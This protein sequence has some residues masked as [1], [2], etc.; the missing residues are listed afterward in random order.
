MMLMV[1]HAWNILERTSTSLEFI[2]THIHMSKINQKE[3]N[4]MPLSTLTVGMDRGLAA[5]AK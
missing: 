3:W 4:Y 5:G 1:L 2:I